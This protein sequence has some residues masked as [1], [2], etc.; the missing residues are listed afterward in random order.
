[1]TASSPEA[2]FPSASTSLEASL[3]RPEQALVADIYAAAAEAIP[4]EVEAD[5]LYWTRRSIDTIASLQTTSVERQKV[6][7]ARV[8]RAAWGNWETES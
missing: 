7:A 6:K 5:H 4:P 1:M 2:M 8:V 3:P